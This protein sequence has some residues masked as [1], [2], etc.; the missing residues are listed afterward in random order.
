MFD[1]HPT[2]IADLCGR[3]LVIACETQKDGKLKAD[4]VKRLTGNA[5]LKARFMKKDFF[6]FDRTFKII[7]CTNHSPEIPENTIAIWERLKVV[8]FTVLA[9]VGS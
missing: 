4:T 6:E 9:R 3:R 5:R 8:P 1:E 7:M 2:E